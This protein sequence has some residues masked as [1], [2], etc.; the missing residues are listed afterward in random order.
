VG[1]EN[2]ERRIAVAMCIIIVAWKVHP[3]YPLVV[4]ANRDIN[5]A[6]PTRAADFWPDAPRLLAGRDLVANGTWLGIT[7]DMRFAAVTNFREYPAKPGV[8]SRGLLTRDYLLGRDDPASYCA[9]I[10]RDLY[11][12][13]SLLVADGTH[14]SYVS[15]RDGALRV[16]GSGI[17]GLSNSLLETPWPKVT[18]AKDAFNSAL[19]KLPRR[20]EF[21]RFLSDE[22][23]P[24]YETFPHTGVP[25]EIERLRSAVFIQSPDYGTVSSTLLLVSR[26]GRISL[27]ERSFGPGGQALGR[28]RKIC[29]S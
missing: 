25:I 10:E 6:R 20:A 13:F 9:Q 19:D 2:A 5:Y 1:I 4:A 28:V 8:R 16:L 12:G 11:E 21:F 24:P 26:F 15:N 3:D 17:Y 29:Q 22:P 23:R 27:E 18:R 7:R 14:L